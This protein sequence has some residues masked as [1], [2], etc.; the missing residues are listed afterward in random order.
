[1]LNPLFNVFKAPHSE[2]TSRQGLS[3]TLPELI[4][5]K[6]HAHHSKCLSS[7][8]SAQ[9]QGLYR[10]N[11]KGRGMDF[12]EIRHYQAGDDIR[13]MEWR[14]TAKTGKPHIKLYEE[15]RERPIILV[16]DFNPSMYF[17]TK[18]AFKSYIATELAAV[19]AWYAN[20]MGDKIGG[21]IFTNESHQEIT[22][23]GREAGVLP[24]LATLAEC[25]QN[26]K[27]K[28]ELD[29]KEA[30][31]NALVR[32]RHSV[33]PGS[34]IVF[35]SDFYTLDKTAIQQLGRLRQHNEIL[36]YHITDLLERQAPPQG[37][38]PLTDGKKLSA[39]NT[40]D[41]KF[42][43]A[44]N[45]ACVLRLKYVKEA[46]QKLTASYIHV[47]SGHDLATLV[48]QTFPRRHHG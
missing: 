26:W 36:A 28:H 47:T 29:K 37:I 6:R 5:L 31:S 13:H 48:Y 41:K 44:Y 8:I 32:L 10:A 14:V 27:R 18:S 3:W 39:I 43:Q 4:A 16:V 45:E 40:F 38:Y 7:K 34:L 46:F 25:S 22:P 24:L 1:M 23:K 11:R 35:I 33:K 20:A 21:F 2:L 42:H 30:L 15:E 19:I 12:A 17:G 9:Q